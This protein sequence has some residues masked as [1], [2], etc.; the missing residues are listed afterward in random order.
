M[1]REKEFVMLGVIVEE[2]EMFHHHKA[3]SSYTL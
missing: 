2:N 3:D 1:Q